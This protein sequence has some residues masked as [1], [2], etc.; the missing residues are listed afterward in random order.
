MIDSSFLCDLF[1]VLLKFTDHAKENRMNRRASSLLIIATLLCCFIPSFIYALYESDVG[2]ADWLKENVGAVKHVIFPSSEGKKDYRNPKQ[3]LV[4]TEQNVLAAIKLRTGAIC[5]C[6]LCVLFLSLLTQL[7]AWRRVFNENDSIDALKRVS[8]NHVLSFSSG[9]TLAQ[10][11]D[12][13]GA[14]LWQV[15]SDVSDSFSSACDAVA[16]S[17]KSVAVLT[18]ERIR[19]VNINSGVVEWEYKRENS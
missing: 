7:I 1:L 19:S 11:W 6:E 17:Q 12:V 13:N 18:A 8:E 15:R 3:L 4:S 2:Q 16:I 10:L 9:C 14:K 5:M